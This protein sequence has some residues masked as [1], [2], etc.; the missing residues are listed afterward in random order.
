ML[1]IKSLE[2]SNIHALAGYAVEGLHRYD[3]TKIVSFYEFLITSIH[4]MTEGRDSAH[5]ALK[6]TALISTDILTRM[7]QSQKIFMHD[8]LQFDKKESITKEDLAMS[9]MERGIQFDDHELTN[10]FNSLKFSDNESDT[11]SR[12]EV[13]VNGH[14]FQL[15]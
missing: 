14:L 15:P 7:S 10:F 11:L 1:D 2:Q 12:L 4:T 6:I 5:L 9:L 13:Y 3:D 8:I